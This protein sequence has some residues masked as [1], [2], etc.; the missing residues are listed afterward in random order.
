MSDSKRKLAALILLPLF[1]IQLVNANVI[2]DLRILS[3]SYTTS[4]NFRII[5]KNNDQIKYMQGIFSEPGNNDITSIM[6]FIAEHRSAFGILSLEQDLVLKRQFKSPSGQSHFTFGQ[7]YKDLPVLYKE[8]KIHTN[9]DGQISSISNQF[10]EPVIYNINPSISVQTALTIAKPLVSNRTYL[11]DDQLAVYVEKGQSYLVYKLDLAGF[12]ISKTFLVDA[13]NGN[14][15]NEIMQTVDDGPTVGQGMT[16]LGTIVDELHIY[17]GNGFIDQNLLPDYLCEEFCWEYGDC[18]NENYDNCEL[19]FGQGSC[20]EGFIE[21]CSGECWN[22]ELFIYSFWSLGDGACHT[23]AQPDHPNADSIYYLVDQSAP[24]LGNLYTLSSYS[25]N[26]SSIFWT[27]SED[28]IFDSGDPSR[29]ELSGTETHHYLRKGLDYFHDHH[30]YEGVDNAGRRLG[31]IVDFI[32]CN[33]YY[34]HLY[35]VTS[36]GLGGECNNWTTLPWSADPDIVGHELAH[37]ITFHSSGL[38][39]QNHAGALNESFSD[40]F[41]Y[42]IEHNI[43]GNTS[44]GM[45]TEIF[46]YPEGNS[47][48]DISNP[49]LYSDPDRLFGPYYVAETSYDNPNPSNDYGGVH[50]NSGIP[51]KVFY[52][53]VEGGIHYGWEIE[54]LS[55]DVD[56]SREMAAELVFVW[57]TQYLSATDDFWDARAKMLLVASDY[58]P[59]DPGIWLSVFNAWSSV[60]VYPQVEVFIPSGYFTPGVDTVNVT[61]DIGPYNEEISS[62]RIAITSS[63]STILDTLDMPQQSD[64]FYEA[65]YP[66]PDHEDLFYFSLLLEVMDSLTIDHGSIGQLITAGP[67]EVYDFSFLGDPVVSP[68]ESLAMS[69]ELLN[70]GASGIVPGVTIELIDHDTT[71]FAS[72]SNNSL[73]YGSMAPQETLE[74]E[75]GFFMIDIDDDCDEGHE[76]YV[77]L[78]IMVMSDVCW[79]DTISFAIGEQLNIDA[80]RIPKEFSLNHSYPNPFNPVTTL[81]YELPKDAF[82]NLTVFDMMGRQ[83]K[84]LVDV[85]QSSGIKTVKWD[86]TNEQGEAVSAGVYLYKLKAGNF[87]ETKKMILL[88]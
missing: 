40:I 67:I 49:P 63:D 29:S 54:P 58:F 23:N 64:E 27:S 75:A 16:N 19:S 33:A 44:W 84:N 14:I 69:V 82:V 9:R 13:H 80:D 32:G 22:D 81:S 3:N 88:K 20:D 39:Y 59:D 41:G 83:I 51:N 34:N 38:L 12:P 71:C 37:G 86:A 48:R 35:D 47:L 15:V 56:I 28:T 66:I 87:I 46:I 52:L 68:G 17:E 73:F 76:T 62:M 74:Q 79:T 77:V 61:A 31:V 85:Q 65:S 30:D 8:I 72:V 1:F 10:I 26:F 18:D 55:D 2:N 11:K 21:D 45:A 43:T 53:L 60:G 42:L 4:D 50:T 24:E 6:N 25:T 7:T 70:S 57:N 5:T 78:N 36:Y